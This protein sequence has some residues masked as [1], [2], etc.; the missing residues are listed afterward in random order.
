MQGENERH[1]RQWKK[2]VSKDTYD[3]SPIKRETS[4]TQ[5]VSARKFHV[6]VVQNNGIEMYK[7][8]VLH[9]KVAC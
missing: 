8:G 6:V 2:K 4:C 5:E 9:P 7:K 3:I 1:V